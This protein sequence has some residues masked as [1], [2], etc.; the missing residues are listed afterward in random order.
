MVTM[1]YVDKLL[2]VSRAAAE[3]SKNFERSIRS[4]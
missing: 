4:T 1:K 3:V 2:M